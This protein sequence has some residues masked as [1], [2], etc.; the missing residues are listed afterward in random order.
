MQQRTLKTVRVRKTACR[1]S[2]VPGAWGNAL[3]TAQER[4][5]LLRQLIIRAAAQ[6]FNR[7]GFH[8]TSMDDISEKNGVDGL[9]KIRITLHDYI[10]DLI[11]TFGHPVV[12]LEDGALV[13]RRDLAERRFRTL[14]AEGIADGGIEPCDTKLAMFALFGAVNWVPKWCH[15][16][17]EWSVEQISDN[18]VDLITRA[19][20]ARLQPLGPKQ[21]PRAWTVGRSESPSLNHRS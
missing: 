2:G 21:A 17:G 19:I 4:N 10:H 3:P 13:R 16:D 18:L 8:G 14:I 11:G 7:S 9:D 20:A 12:R 5:S 15:P 6:C 1:N